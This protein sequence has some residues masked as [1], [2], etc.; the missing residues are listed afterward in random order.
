LFSNWRVSNQASEPSE[1]AL[2]LSKHALLD[3]LHGLIIVLWQWIGCEHG[4]KLFLGKLIYR[5]LHLVVHHMGDPDIPSAS[6]LLALLLELFQISINCLMLEEET[7]IS[8]S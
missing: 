7:L 3:N 8:E 2:M 5:I 4:V 6:S 1:G